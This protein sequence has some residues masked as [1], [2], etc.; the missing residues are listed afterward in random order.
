MGYYKPVQVISSTGGRP[1]PQGPQGPSGTSIVIESDVTPTTRVD[2][3]ALQIG[4]AWWDASTS[5]LLYWLPDATD[6]YSWVQTSQE[7][8]NNRRATLSRISSNQ[9]SVWVGETGP[10]ADPTGVLGWHFASD[11]NKILWNLWEQ[12]NEAEVQVTFADLRSASLVLRNAGSRYP[13]FS[14]YTRRKNDGNDIN[15]GY[16]SRYTFETAQDDSGLPKMRLMTTSA[17]NP[18]YSNLPHTTLTL[19]PGSSVGPQ[20]PDEIVKNISLSSNSGATAG[21]FTFTAQE[22][23]LDTT[24]EIFHIELDFTP[25]VDPNTARVYTQDTNPGIIGRKNGDLWYNT[26]S[27]VLSIWTG[28]WTSL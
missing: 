20:E 24:G 10:V 22:L 28:S 8:I 3:T 14:I 13:Y 12:D 6:T 25:V 16:R 4:D 11:N 27:S 21:Q 19:S 26:N 18:I 17:D 9:Q 2:G 5:T 7:E 1:G 15:V 23:I